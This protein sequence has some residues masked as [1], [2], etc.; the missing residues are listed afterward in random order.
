MFNQL[1]NIAS[2]TQW[3][4]ETAISDCP[5]KVL[6]WLLDSTSLTKK[7]EQQCNQFN[8]QVKQEMQTHSKESNLSPYFPY[9]EPLFVREVLLQC[10]GIA[11]V[12]AQTEIPQQTLLATKEKLTHL[13]ERS[14]GSVLF[15][16]PTLIRGK[17][18]VAEFPI[19]SLLH[20]FSESLQQPCEH[21]LWGRRSIFQF[22]NKPLLVSELFLPCSR[23][24]DK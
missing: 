6:S 1:L 14:L 16:D 24:Y 20:L 19:G 3:Q 7:L 10:D 15:N 9:P 22:Q 23:I 13:G 8:V 17:I 12:F 21:S 11:H 5:E 4:E 18:E 2:S